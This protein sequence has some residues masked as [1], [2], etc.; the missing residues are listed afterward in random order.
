MAWT[1]IFTQVLM[2]ITI[3]NIKPTIRECIQAP[4]TTKIRLQSVCNRMGMIRGEKTP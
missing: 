3:K 2:S 1:I 4:R